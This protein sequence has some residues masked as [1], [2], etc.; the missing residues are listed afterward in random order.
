MQ[1]PNNRA[2]GGFGDNP[3]NINRKGRPKKGQTLTDLM[4]EYLD[5]PTEDKTTTLKEVFIKKVAKMA[6]DGDMTAIKLVWNY[7]DG[8]PKQTIEA[9]VTRGMENLSD[10]EIEDALSETFED[11]ENQT[12]SE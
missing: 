3:Q 4:R 6:Y 11:G 2:K 1:T 12:N 10:E 8:M 9:S 5:T 7:L